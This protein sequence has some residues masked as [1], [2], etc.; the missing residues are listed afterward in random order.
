LR[1]GELNNTT[2]SRYGRQSI[3]QTPDIRKMF[4]K[5]LKTITLSPTDCVNL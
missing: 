4:A 2:A 3:N 5:V 1:F